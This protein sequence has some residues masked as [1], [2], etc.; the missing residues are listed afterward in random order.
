MNR[1]LLII[2]AVAAAMLC[3]SSAM[4]QRKETLV[5]APGV[6][7]PGF[8]VQDGVISAH[9]YGS[10]WEY[11]ETTGGML[12]SLARGERAGA[13]A[14]WYLNYDHQG[15][16]PRVI[17]VPEPTVGCV[18]SWAEGPRVRKREFGY[19][20][21]VTVKPAAG[22]YAGWELTSDK[23]GP[24]LRE[25]GDPSVQFQVNIDDLEDGK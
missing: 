7:L 25:Q 9:Q 18:W 5:R 8:Q 1:S 19:Y 20:H 16:D 10:R 21:K 4:A 2:T 11:R 14:G 12:I 6:E 13:Y 15:K 3:A 24:L 22:G 23:K 17:L